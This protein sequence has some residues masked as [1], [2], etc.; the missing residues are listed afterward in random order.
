M[1]SIKQYIH[2]LPSE[3]KA[4]LDSIILE[5][6]INKKEKV[7]FNSNYNN[8]AI[9]VVEGALRKYVLKDGEEKTIDFYLEDSIFFSPSLDYAPVYPFY[10]ESMKNSIIYVVDLNSFDKIKAEK[11]TLLQLELMLTAE[12]SKQCHYRLETFQLL[13]ATERYLDLIK[14][15]SKIVKNIPLKYIASYLGINNASLSKIRASLA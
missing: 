10:L 7:N 8:K 5:R 1:N 11:K 14:Q 6:N 3:D 13:N 4:I 9:Y 2:E 12:V 15:N